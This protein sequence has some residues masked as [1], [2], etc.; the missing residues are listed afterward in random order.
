MKDKRK[1]DNLDPNYWV[2]LGDGSVVSRMHNERVMTLPVTINLS[3][4]EQEES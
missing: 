1:E 4:K 3:P 2:R